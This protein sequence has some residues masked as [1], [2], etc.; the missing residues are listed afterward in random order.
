MAAATH[1]QLPILALNKIE[2]ASD[3]GL[4]GTAHDQHWVLVEGAIEDQAT[5]FIV[6]CSRGD[7]AAGN[8]GSKPLNG[9]RIERR[10]ILLAG[11]QDRPR[12]SK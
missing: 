5:G 8:Q 11:F 3:V 4:G 9:S 2:S 7:D 12:F 6:G 1:R 10:C